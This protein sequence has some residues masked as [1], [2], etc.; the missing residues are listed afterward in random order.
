MISNLSKVILL[1]SYI[2]Y[3]AAAIFYFRDDEDGKLGKISLIFIVAFLTIII[4][5][6]VYFSMP[7]LP[8]FSDLNLKPGD[9]MKSLIS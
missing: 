9:I 8:N 7:S 3:F 4:P 6:V 1:A 5:L 2:L